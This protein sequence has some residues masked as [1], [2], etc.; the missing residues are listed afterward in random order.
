MRVVFDAAALHDGV[1]LNS[2]L[3]Q[4]PDLTNNLL[5]VLLRFREE[6]VAIAADIE[7]MFLQVKVPPED[8]DALRFLWWENGD[9]N[10]T[11]SEYQMV[12]HIFGATDSPSSA[13]YSLK[14]TA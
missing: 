8:S 9:L 10:K 4:V 2:Q 12:R 13:N 5:G 11:P 14:R 6:P 7:A 1:S 3:L